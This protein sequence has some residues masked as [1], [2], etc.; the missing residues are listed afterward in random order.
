M[1]AGPASS[2]IDGFSGFGNFFR[3]CK[4]YPAS[5]YFGV[6][7]IQLVKFVNSWPVATSLPGLRLQNRHISGKHGTIVGKFPIVH[8]ILTIKC[9]KLPLL[10]SFSVMTWGLEPGL[11]ISQ[12][13]HFTRGVKVPDV[14]SIEN[15]LMMK[16]LQTARSREKLKHMRSPLA[17]FMT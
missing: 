5:L 8:N 10:I 14:S 1:W 16:D 11:Y 2:L 7:L 9:F 4:V 15:L 12:Q 17:D 3:N 6:K 13:F